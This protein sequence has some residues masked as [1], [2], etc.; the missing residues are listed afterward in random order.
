[1]RIIVTFYSQ[2]GNTRKVADAIFTEIAGEKELRPLQEVTSLDGYDLV[3]LGFPIIQ[4]GPPRVIRNFLTKYAAG[5]KVALFV[6][7]ASWDSDELRPALE[8]W[9]SK[10]RS[11][12]SGSEVLGFFDCRGTLSESSAKLFLMSDIPEVQYFGSLQAQTKGHPDEKDLQRAKEF[13][14]MIIERLR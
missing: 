10:C 2:T 5:K 3:F 4:F 14:R 11:A 8:L 7:H 12:A 9:L 1:M 13:T 6:T